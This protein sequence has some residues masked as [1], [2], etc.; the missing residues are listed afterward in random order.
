V[1]L[2]EDEVSALEE[3]YTPR[4]PTYYGSKAGY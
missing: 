2:T 3:H 1:T 4:K